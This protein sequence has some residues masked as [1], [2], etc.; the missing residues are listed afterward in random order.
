[1][2]CIAKKELFYLWPF[3]LTAYLTG[4]VF[5]DRRKR[6]EAYKTL[7]AASEVMTRDKV[8]NC[9]ATKL[10]LALARHFV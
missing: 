9:L 6:K 2:T 7:F 8:M 4:I 1:M 5:I 10:L 3:G